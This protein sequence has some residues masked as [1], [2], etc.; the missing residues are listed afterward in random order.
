[1]KE[2]FLKSYD[3][4]P[5]RQKTVERHKHFYKVGIDKYSNYT[6]DKITP[7]DIQ[8]SINAYSRNH[9]RE[10]TSHLLA[11]WRRIYK[12]AV[13]LNINIPDRTIPVV[14]PECKKEEP[15][16][17]EIS[18]EDL[19]LFL[20]ALEEYNGGEIR[21]AYENKCLYYVIQVMRY[22]G[23]RPAEALAL[24]R[25]DIYLTSDKTGYI[26]INKAVH[27]T[28]ESRNEIGTTKTA[29][30]NRVV[31]VPADLVPILKECLIWSKYELIFSDYYGNI[32][33][34]D[35]V[36][37]YIRRVAR[38]AGIQFNLYMLRHQLSTDLFST[39]I[40]PAVIRDILGHESIDMS[41][42]Y[43]VSKEEEKEKALEKRKFS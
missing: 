10:Q 33:S 19:L 25:Q 31:P 18:S 40:N 5:V 14:I 8:E 2:I 37:D 12:T 13:M 26:S 1:M 35:R 30:S 17:K 29:K 34:I 15:R 27:S 32:Q 11:V 21:A 22:T 42:Y 3:V 43:A 28:I 38:K 16:K 36:S 6:I 7:A 23:I 41:L 20:E 39:G 4:L 9:T 24:S